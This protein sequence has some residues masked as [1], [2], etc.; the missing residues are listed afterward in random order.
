MAAMP[1]RSVNL[2]VTSPPYALEFKKEYGNA[3]K[4]AYVNWLRP[5]VASR[6]CCKS[7]DGRGSSTRVG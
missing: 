4:D 2:V 3:A 5:L 6:N 7:S 1:D